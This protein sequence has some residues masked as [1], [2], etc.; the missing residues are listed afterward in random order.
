MSRLRSNQLPTD[1]ERDQLNEV[2]FHSQKELVQYDTTIARLHEMIVSL[3]NEKRNLDRQI[4]LTR[5][6]MAPIR[7]LPTEI[8]RQIFVEH[9]VTNSI[10]V[11]GS[12]IPGLKIASI[13][14]HW[15]SIAVDTTALWNSISIRIRKLRR[16]WPAH[17]VSLVEKL[18]E[19]SQTS[20]LHIIIDSEGIAIPPFLP[21]LC[22]QADRWQSLSGK[23]L[24][25]NILDALSGIQGHLHRL[26]TF[27]MLCRFESSSSLLAGGVPELHSLA[28]CGMPFDTENTTIPWSQII[29][30]HIVYSRSTEILRILAESPDLRTL[31]IGHYPIR[32]DGSDVRKHEQ[33]LHPS[34]VLLDIALEDTNDAMNMT[35]LLN[36]LDLPNLRS[37]SIASTSKD[38]SWQ[39]KSVDQEIQSRSHWSKQLPSFLSRSSAITTF[40]LRSIWVS[41]NDLIALLQRMPALTTFSMSEPHLV[42]S[43]KSLPFILNDDFLLS[44]SGRGLDDRQ[45]LL[46]RLTSLSLRGRSSDSFSMPVFIDII[47]SRWK[48][49]SLIEDEVACIRRVKLQVLENRIDPGIVHPLLILE[50]R[51]LDVV[52]KDK[53]GIVL[54]ESQIQD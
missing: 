5:S 24:C 43:E 40:T 26:H 16:E 25:N 51:G 41:T 18:L 9:G 3:E 32:V 22:A 53:A 45:P 14:S 39:S 36:L 50:K 19:L 7:K 23:W 34:L 2:V 52:I 21:L 17:H 47:Q 46:T 10:R 12:V 33:F 29:H 31:K 4:H 13:C 44:I 28:L 11:T 49:S 48:P 20:R 27:D 37:L 30:L 35:K 6:L 38:Q 8:L 42:N 54:A 1:F 15:R